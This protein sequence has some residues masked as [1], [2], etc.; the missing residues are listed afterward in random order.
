MNQEPYISGS[1]VWTITKIDSAGSLITQITT[2]NGLAMETVSEGG[3]FIGLPTTPTDD[4]GQTI[5]RGSTIYSGTSLLS[6][7]IITQNTAAATATVGLQ[8]T[9][10]KTQ[11]TSSNPLVES[12]TYGG[13]GPTSALRPTSIQQELNSATLVSAPSAV[14]SQPFGP[15]LEQAKTSATVQTGLEQSDSTA[16]VSSAASISNA[17]SSPI[18]TSSPRFEIPLSD[19][20]AS[21]PGASNPLPTEHNTVAPIASGTFTDPVASSHLTGPS[22]TGSDAQIL[23]EPLGENSVSVASTI[24]PG[25]K[26]PEVSQTASSSTPNP[27]APGLSSLSDTSITPSFELEPLV[28]TQITDLQGLSTPA[29]VILT[30]SP[31]GA[32]STS[33][34]PV[35]PIT[36][37]DLNPTSTMDTIPPG[38]SVEEATNPAWTTNTWITT[39]TLGG[40][41]PT[42]VPVLVGCP[43]CGA[44]GHGLVL[45]NLPRLSGVQF[46]F[47]SLPKVPRFHIPCLRIFG[48]R[49]GSCSEPSKL[50]DIVTDPPDPSDPK[51]KPGSNKGSVNPEDEQ[52]DSNDEQSSTASE[53]KSTSQP[54]STGTSSMSSSSSS[55][56]SSCS[57]GLT[58]DDI[59]LCSI[60]TLKA[61]VDREV[62][63]PI[64]SVLPVTGTNKP[65]NTIHHMISMA[66]ST[67]F[68]VSTGVS[69]PA[70][71]DI[72]KD[73]DPNESMTSSWSITMTSQ[74]NPSPSLP[75]PLPIS[76]PTTMNSQEN[77]SP[78]LPGPLPISV[79]TSMASQEISVP[80]LFGPLSD[81]TISSQAT[82][83][84]D[85]ASSSMTTSIPPE[86]ST[87]ALAPAE[88]APS[89]PIFAPVD[90]PSEPE[91]YPSPSGKYKDAHKETVAEASIPPFCYDREGQ[92]L[93]E[94]DAKEEV[95]FDGLITGTDNGYS[96]QPEPS[97][98][99]WM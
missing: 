90:P 12:S 84:S 99:I 53:P 76:V 28:T 87:S 70:S 57:N 3:S 4:P 2:V 22:M 44:R 79:P 47:P 82:F 68:P 58:I 93:H 34:I 51:P 77:S 64:R 7:D 97:K 63:M 21:T 46:H 50:P 75:G 80:S 6:Q 24:L 32:T 71:F 27:G 26:T 33:L 96:S 83:N 48:I 36:A 55:S 25:A 35:L 8:D 95:K 29:V 78:P 85:A 45:W 30:T 42:I 37:T 86:T 13:S 72:S 23:K 67:S 56:T 60:P 61:A 5:T 52:S 62:E 91:C 98:R 73:K 92:I 14:G 41:D 74:E 65:P 19:N 66:S 40:S 17:L 94:G 89:E 39:T 18:P 20:V 11:A 81:A 69:T 16:I 31:G 10:K 1:S 54:S 49:V 43:G 9:T 59:T 38:L 88:N 15:V